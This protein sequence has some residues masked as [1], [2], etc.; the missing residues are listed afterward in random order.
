MGFRLA[1]FQTRFSDISRL[2][3]TANMLQG[4]HTDKLPYH[5]TQTI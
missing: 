2:V 3:T 5:I 1:P 4:V